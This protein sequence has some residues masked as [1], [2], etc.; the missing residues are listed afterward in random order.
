MEGLSNLDSDFLARLRRRDPETLRAVVD[1]HGRPLY[2]AA[3][4]MGCSID[5]AYDL[6]QDVFVVF[7]KSLDR[8]EGRSQVGTWLFGILHHKI[9]EARRPSS[10]DE[11]RDPI[12]N[13][14]DAQFDRADRWIQRPI[15]PD[16][17]MHSR[18][19]SVAIR[20]CLEGLTPQQRDVFH[21]RQ[22]EG[23]SGAEVSTILG[24]SVS[25]IGVLLHRARLRLRDC[26]ERKGWKSA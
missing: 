16:R 15:E 5:A 25:H 10:Y 18:E 22:V 3:R 1:S 24:E 4:A 14:F 26:L 19:A 6:V 13:V 7:L 12:D 8:F 17:W 23:L 11:R 9:R 21:M 2:R 20:G